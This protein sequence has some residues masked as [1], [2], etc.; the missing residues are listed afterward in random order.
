MILALVLNVLSFIRYCPRCLIFQPAYENL[1]APKIQW[2]G[3][4]QKNFG[5]FFKNQ[6]SRTNLVI[7][8]V[9]SISFECSVFIRHC[10]RFL[11]FEH[12]STC[13]WEMMKIAA[14]ILSYYT[15][16]RYKVIKQR[17]SF[18]FPKSWWLAMDNEKFFR[19]SKKWGGGGC[20]VKK[21]RGVNTQNTPRLRH[22]WLYSIHYTVCNG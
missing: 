14:P 19:R 8:D 17:D 13:I 9:F 4:A 12:V 20:K 2:K 11:T 10:P 21:V 16:M 5:S 1:W 6:P 7:Q 3:G 15:D 18:R 22:P